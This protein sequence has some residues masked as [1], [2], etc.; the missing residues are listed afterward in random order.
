VPVQKDGAGYI[1][2]YP[3]LAPHS[4]ILL[5]YAGSTEQ[6]VFTAVSGAGWLAAL[7]AL[8]YSTRRRRKRAESP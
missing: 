4:E 7:A 8:R 1:V 6:K 5:R 2:F 3:E